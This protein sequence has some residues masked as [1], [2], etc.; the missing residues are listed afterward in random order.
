MWR[1]VLPMGSQGKPI[2]ATKE[3]VYDASQ[4]LPKEKV[5]AD[6]KFEM[7]VRPGQQLFFACAD[8]NGNGRW[9]PDGAEPMGWY[10]TEAAGDM[11]AVDVAEEDIEGIDIELKAPTPFAREEQVT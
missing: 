8:L 7:L 2:P 10:A 5:D 9:D 6:G 4:R 11:A 1:I 3:Q